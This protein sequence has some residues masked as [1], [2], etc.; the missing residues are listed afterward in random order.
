MSRI[1]NHKLWKNNFTLLV[2]NILGYLCRFILFNFKQAA[3]ADK[4]KLDSH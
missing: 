3:S 2:C 1:T 4:I